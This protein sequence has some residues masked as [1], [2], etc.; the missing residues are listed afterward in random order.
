MKEVFK[1]APKQKVTDVRPPF[2]F[3][4]LA[5]G[6]MG[7]V[8]YSPFPVLALAAKYSAI[9]C[10]LNVL[11]LLARTQTLYHVSCPDTWS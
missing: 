10:E 9:E 6:S 7:H 1:F 2:H 4:V 5:L 8:A 3:L 11:S